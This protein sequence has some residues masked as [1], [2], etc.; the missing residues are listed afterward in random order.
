MLSKPPGITGIWF[1]VEDVMEFMGR[2][3]GDRLT[4]GQSA[5]VVADDLDELERLFGSPNFEDLAKALRRLRLL[6]EY[7][8]MPWPR[9][10]VKFKGT[11]WG[12][13]LGVTIWGQRLTLDGSVNS[14]ALTPDRWHG[15]P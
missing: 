15:T 1:N 9:A 8:N 5:K 2:G 12:H 13:D 11:I 14:P 7:R 10:V 3:V 6:R 4:F